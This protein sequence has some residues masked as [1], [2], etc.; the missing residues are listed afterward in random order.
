MKGANVKR[1]QEDCLN[2]FC[3]DKGN[4]NYKLNC[5]LCTLKAHQEQLYACYE[6]LRQL[7]LSILEH[8]SASLELNGV[9][10]VV[11]GQP[12]IPA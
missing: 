2:V 1:F 4:R 7:R 11:S 6:S 3:E 5:T 10:A 12:Y 8:E 9:D